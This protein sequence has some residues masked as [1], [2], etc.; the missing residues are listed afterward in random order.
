MSKQRVGAI[1][2]RE[3]LSRGR[4]RV[5]NSLL[6]ARIS[7]KMHLRVASARMPRDPGGILVPRRAEECCRDRRKGRW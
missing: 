3:F 6:Y 7:E 2:F 1:I 5:L 4:F